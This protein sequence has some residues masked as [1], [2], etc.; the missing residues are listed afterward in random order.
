VKVSKVVC[1]EAAEGEAVEEVDVE[2]VVAEGSPFTDLM[3]SHHRVPRPPSL[4]VT[5][6]RTARTAGTTT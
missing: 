6:S 3:D 1:K 4:A 2:D 5:L